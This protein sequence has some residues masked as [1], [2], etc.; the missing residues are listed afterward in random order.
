MESVLNELATE[1]KGK[2]I[3]GI[4]P[5]AERKLFTTYGVKGIPA[6]FIWHNSEVKQSYIGFR[7]KAFLAKALKEYV[8]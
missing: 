1:L 2:A 5:Q 4:V 3:V 6:T 7:D 8:N